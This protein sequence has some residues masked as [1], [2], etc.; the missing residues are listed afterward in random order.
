MRVTVA[1]ET[2]LE[3]VAREWAELAGEAIA[4]QRKG[5]PHGDL[6]RRADAAWKRLEEL[7]RKAGFTA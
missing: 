5:S 4:A 2:Q 7:R 1:D 3:K 6:L